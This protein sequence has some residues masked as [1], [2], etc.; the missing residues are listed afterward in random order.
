MF[1]LNSWCT[2]LT[3]W[4]PPEIVFLTMK[5]GSLHRCVKVTCKSG[6]NCFA[7]QNK[8]IAYKKCIKTRH[9][10]TAGNP[11]SDLL[12]CVHLFLQ[13]LIDQLFTYS[14][15]IDLQKGSGN[16]LSLG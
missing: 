9:Q 11:S 13:P 4:N 7:P 8:T 15:H 3:S 16:V 2:R 6:L 5:W 10:S 1:C 12:D 14:W